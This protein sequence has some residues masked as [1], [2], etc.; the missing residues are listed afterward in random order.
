[1]LTIPVMPDTASV[2]VP[3]GES[4]PRALERITHLGVG[5]NPDDLEFHGLSRSRP[6]LRAR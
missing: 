2:Y 1:M 5:A 6:V 4:L 3:D